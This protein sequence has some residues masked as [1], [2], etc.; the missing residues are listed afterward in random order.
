MQKLSELSVFFP[1]YNEESNLYEAVTSADKV[2]Q[3]VALKYE[4]I[5]VNDGSK[6][7]TAEVAS[8]LAS[9]NPHVKI[10]THYPNKGYGG[11]LKSGIYA[12]QYQ[13]IAFTDSDGQFDFQQIQRF[14][15]YLDTYKMV[16]GYRVKRA[17][18][19]ARYLNAKAWGF[20]VNILF[21]L[22]IKDVDCAFKVFNKEIINTIP[23]LES[24]GALI[25]TELLAKTRKNGFQIKQIAV[26]HYPRTGG[27]PTGANIKVIVK[28][29]LELFKLWRKLK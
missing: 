28:A 23:H 3:E 12:A 20:L 6:D 11:A 15:P 25:S 27:N 16:V 2:C 8:Q 10:I 21:S 4:I 17:E 13:T 5:I 1:A 26:S 9:S 22:D 7:K 19:M 18:G 14:I 29:F 24:D